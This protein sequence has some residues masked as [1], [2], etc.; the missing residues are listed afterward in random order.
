[1]VHSGRLKKTAKAFGMNTWETKYLSYDLGR[2]DPIYIK[3]VLYHELC[4]FYVIEHNDDFYRVLD[5]RMENGSKIDKELD[6]LIY[7]DQF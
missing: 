3:T 5:D 4:H 1:M 2:Y 7:V 6:K